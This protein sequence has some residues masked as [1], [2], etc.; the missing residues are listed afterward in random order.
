VASDNNQTKDSPPPPKDFLRSEAFGI[1]GKGCVYSY[2]S[3]QV[4]YLNLGI[5]AWPFLPTFLQPM[6]S[7]HSRLPSSSSSVLR[8]FVARRSSAFSHYAQMR[9]TRMRCNTP[10]A[11]TSE[12]EKAGY[13]SMASLA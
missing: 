10:A 2:V 1:E 11:E 12:K 4:A 8:D 3:G 6:P 7:T 5:L 9:I 13:V